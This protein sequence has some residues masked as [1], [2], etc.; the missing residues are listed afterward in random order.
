MKEHEPSSVSHLP[1][2]IR[3][4]AVE[5]PTHANAPS[6]AVAIS[7]P[8]PRSTRQVKCLTMLLGLVEDGTLTPDEL[9]QHILGLPITSQDSLAKK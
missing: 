1:A 8:L 4:P 7:S 6:S 2:P 3:K 9:K 5:D